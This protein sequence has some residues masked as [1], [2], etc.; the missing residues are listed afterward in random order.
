VKHRRKKEATQRMIERECRKEG[1][2]AVHV[3]GRKGEERRKFKFL[4]EYI[5]KARSGR[6]KNRIRKTHYE[7]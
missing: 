2:E 1:G 7:E 5:K 6:R 4:R 3:G